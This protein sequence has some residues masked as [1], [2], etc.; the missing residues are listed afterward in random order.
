[1]LPAT[2]LV[3]FWLYYG[4]HKSFSV[5]LGC[6]LPMLV[7]YACAPWW[8]AD[9]LASF[10][11]DAV[12]LL[13]AGRPK[14]LLG[15]YQTAIGMRLFSPPALR[16]ER[17]AM[18][19]AEAG[20]TLAARIAFKEALDEHGDAV[21]LRVM[22][23]YA[24][25]SFVLGEDQAAIP[26]YRRLLAS[27]GSLPGVERHL[28]QAL[29]RQGEDLQQALDLLERAAREP[30]ETLRAELVLVRAVAYAKLGNKR[31]AQELMAQEQSVVSEGANELRAQ[32]GVLLGG[33][34]G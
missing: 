17:K 27:T 16:A 20:K 8:A 1:L 12:R 3:C 11:R 30:D 6:A 31:R 22:L 24:H 4:A 2:I 18:A 7:F 21:P 9:S 13:A 10:D 28:A 33:L 25:T 5:V 19:L 15:R 32:I 29:V 14:S 34:P 23:G 26:M